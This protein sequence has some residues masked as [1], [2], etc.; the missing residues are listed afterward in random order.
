MHKFSN[1]STKIDFAIHAGNG[2][3]VALRD[4]SRQSI[5]C[6]QSAN[7]LTFYTSTKTSEVSL[8]GKLKGGK[9][10]NDA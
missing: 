4:K 2:I 8:N 7:V 1:I 9:F 5:I 3:Y 10:L 6:M